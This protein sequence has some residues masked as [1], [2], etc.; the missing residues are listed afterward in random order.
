MIRRSLLILILL[1]TIFAGV[2]AQTPTNTAAKNISGDNK[3]ARELE[4]ERILKE[5][6]TNA[7][8]LL[9][10]LA[11]DSRN[12]SDQALRARTQARIADALWEVDRERGRTMFRAAWDAAEVAD[13]EAHVGR[14]RPGSGLRFCDSHAAL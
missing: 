7:Q 14:I 13:K 12:F 8:S 9:I 6:R 2:A 10:N 3:A 4:A 1:L 11:A 5:R